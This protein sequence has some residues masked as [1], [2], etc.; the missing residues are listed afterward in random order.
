MPLPAFQALH[1][2]NSQRLARTGCKLTRQKTL[3]IKVSCLLSH[4]QRLSAARKRFNIY[5]FV[6]AKHSWTAKT[7]NRSRQD[8]WLPA[9]G[10]RRARMHCM[11][12]VAE[13]RL[14]RP[15]NK[16]F[17][18]LARHV[19]VFSVI[20]TGRPST[21]PWHPMCAILWDRS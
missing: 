4:S 9:D 12:S 6:R 21:H 11:K 20:L 7:E 8:D 16:S 19:N 14:A 15:C 18:T 13:S 5:R 17:A 10:I 2:D 1:I 3:N